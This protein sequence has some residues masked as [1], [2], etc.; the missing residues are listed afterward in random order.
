MAKKFYAVKRGRKIGIFTSWDEC[1]SYVEGF[2]RPVFKGFMTKTEAEAWL[3]GK[4]MKLNPP[5]DNKTT[6]KSPLDDAASVKRAP[7]D[8][9]IYTDGSCL[10][11]PDGPGGY[12]A[13]IIRKDGTIKKISGGEP[14]TT[15]NRMELRA[16][17]EALRL[18][19]DGSAV[20]FYADSQ[21]LQNAFVKHWI[22]SWKRK[23]WITSLGT[24]VKNKDLWLEFD[25]EFQRHSIRFY[26]VKGHAGNEY[27]EI[28]DKLAKSEAMKFM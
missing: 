28:C 9:I 1:K 23:G 5:A 22:V 14:S 18:L 24:P 12:A 15:N 20:D 8:Y 6:G 2:E 7:A 27:N 19:P 3:H 11:N 13:V 26:W 21:Y 4:K 17:I 16:G 25:D 10:S